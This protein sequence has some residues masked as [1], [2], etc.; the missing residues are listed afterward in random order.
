M[1]P[2]LDHQYRVK[3]VS[4]DNIVVIVLQK[5]EDYWSR[6]DVNN[7]AKLNS[8]YQE[9][10]PNVIW[11]WSLEFDKLQELRIGYAN[12]EAF[13][14]SRVDMVTAAMINY[15]LHPGMTI[16][17]I[18][19]KYVGENRNVKIIIK[20]FFPHIDEVNAGHAKRILT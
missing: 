3:D 10:V 6:E 8:L 4:L 19:G 12:Q 16:R 11:L 9:M 1:K 14:M 17:Y 18:K 5:F 2:S 15:S 7:L 13:Q 20:D